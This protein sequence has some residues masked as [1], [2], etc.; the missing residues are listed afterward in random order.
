MEEKRRRREREDHA[1]DVR[2]RLMD[3]DGDKLL[4]A[5]SNGKMAGVLSGM[6]VLYVF[7]LR[8]RYQ[9]FIHKFDAEEGRRRAFAVDEHSTAMIKNLVSAA[10]ELFEITPRAGMD[11]LGVMAAAERGIISYLDMTGRLPA[12]DVDFMSWQEPPAPGAPEG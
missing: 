9:C 5:L 11:P 12:E 6:E 8:D 1:N 2:L 10:D 4:L 7:L 3:R